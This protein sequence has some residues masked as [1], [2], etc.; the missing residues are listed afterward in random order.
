[1]ARIFK[2]YVHPYDGRVVSNF[3]V[4]ALMGEPITIHGDGSQTRAFC[5]VD[6]LIEDFLRLM[7]AP[8]D[9]TGPINL[10]NPVET[11]AES[12]ECSGPEVEDG[13]A[14]LARLA[15]SSLHLRL[16]RAS[17][18]LAISRQRSSRLPSPLSARG[19]SPMRTE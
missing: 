13:G 19:W 15:G 3:I 12:R 18:S 5:Y 1:V 17:L 4:Q 11:T 10:G 7:A 14:F 6:D 8:D 16:L 9:V 2:T